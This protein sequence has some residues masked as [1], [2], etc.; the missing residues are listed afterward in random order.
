MEQL[1]Q[2]EWKD[3]AMCVYLFPHNFPSLCMP[4]EKI[5]NIDTVSVV[6][7]RKLICGAITLMEEKPLYF[8]YV[9]SKKMKT[10]S[11]VSF[12]IRAQSF[13]FS[14]QKKE[15]IILL[16]KYINEN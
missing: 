7:R 1:G 14:T 4:T 12:I 6:P 11:S 15:W 16:A 9:P 8:T 10:A 3:N 2:V 13:M 5:W